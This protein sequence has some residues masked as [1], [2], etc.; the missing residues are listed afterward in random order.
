[1]AF[2]DGKSAES[3]HY[4]LYGVL[5]HRGEPAGSGCYTV[6]VLH[7]NGDGDG[8]AR[9]HIEDETIGAVGHGSADNE[10]V[11]DQCAYMLFYCRTTPTQIQ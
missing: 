5:Y 6:D 11:D 3:V 2:V 7:A 8:E 1:M 10:R 9:L 4:K